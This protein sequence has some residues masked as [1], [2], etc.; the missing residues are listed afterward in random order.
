VI[1]RRSY[2]RRTA[3]ERSN[4][5][6]KD[7]AGIDVAK[8]WCRLMGLVPI[9]LF[10]ACALVVRNLAVSDAF[11][12]RA[13]DEQRRKDAGLGPRRRRPRSRSLSELAGARRADGEH[14]SITA[15]ELSTTPDR[16]SR[17]ATATP[18]RDSRETAS[19]NVKSSEWALT[20]LNRRPA[21]CKRF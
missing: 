7:P 1:E 6:V 2:A 20:D 14:F 21:R 4:S 18:L 9:S 17:P 3:V 16:A 15:F 8:G 12:E 10:L 5:R 13:L 19:S 11:S